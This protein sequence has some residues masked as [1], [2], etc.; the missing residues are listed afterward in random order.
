MFFEFTVSTPSKTALVD[1]T[2]KIEDCI[3]KSNVK[4]G[5]CFI[6]IPHTT[7][8]VIINENYDPSVVRDILNTLE[9]LIPWSM[10]YSHAEGNAPA[11]I[12]STILGNQV[13]AFIQNGRLKLG[14]WQGIFLAEFDGPRV[15]KV[16]VDIVGE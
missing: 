5:R 16:W 3:R 7:A 1:I 4:E 13:V 10:N 15:R 6:F 14:T 2:E 8:G 11:H 9:K 12:K